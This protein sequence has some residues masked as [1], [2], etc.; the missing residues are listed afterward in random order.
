[1]ELDDEALLQGFEDATLPDTAFHHAQHVRVAWIYVD[2]YGMP[3][4]IQRFT[5]A[6]KRFAAA[7]QKPGLYHETITWA[8]LL[9]IAERVAR[10]PAAGWEGFVAANQDLLQWKPSILDAL[11]TPET[12]WSSLARN[13]FVMPDRS[14]IG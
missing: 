11:Y 5:S 1:M 10:R 2:R 9:L 6:L 13:T 14:S 12:L 8:Y 4:A 3:A 7:K